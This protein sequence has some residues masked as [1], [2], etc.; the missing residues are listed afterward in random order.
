M[1]YIDLTK[2]VAPST[3]AV[4]HEEIYV[5]TVDKRLKTIDDSGSIVKL[6]GNDTT[7][8]LTNKTLTNPIIT[9]VSSDPVS[10]VEGQIW[11]NTTTHQY[12]GYNGT[13]KILLG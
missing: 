6:T 2:T 4:N 10:P 1:S 3:P 9:N 8:I 5:D 7:D 11:Y 13:S 12:M